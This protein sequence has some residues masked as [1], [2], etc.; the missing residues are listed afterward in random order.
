MDP[1]RR[2]YLRTSL[3][4][5]VVFVLGVVVGG[6]ASR[7]TQQRR[8]RELST[9]DPAATRARLTLA[10]LDDLLAL[11]DAQRAEAERLLRAQSERFREAVEPCR[12]RTRALRRELLQQLLPALTADQ[13]A[14]LENLLR[15]G[16]P[17]R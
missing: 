4:V 5:V 2:S 8:I 11:S 13:R 16:E 1:V 6:L 10:A 12:P 14:T 17:V 9:G 7:A 15:K 3:L